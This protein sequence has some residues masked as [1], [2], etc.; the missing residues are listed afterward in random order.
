[1]TSDEARTGRGA[2]PADRRDE[3]GGI[4]SPPSMVERM[5]LVLDA[6][7]D[8]AAR[9]RL[10]EIALRTGLPRSTSHRILDQLVRLGWL[11][12]SSN[13]YALGR[14][15]LRLGG[16]LDDTAEL[17]A[18]AAPVLEKLH[19][20]TGR[21]VC[22]GVLDGANVVFLDRIGGAGA[23]LPSH[24]G[25]RAPA[26]ATALGK[27]MLARLSPEDVDSVFRRGLRPRTHATIT[28]LAV[29]HREL[30]RVRTRH[31]LAFERDEHAVGVSGVAV[32]ISGGER[33]GG[34]CV[35]EPTAG[36]SPER[37][38]PLVRDAATRI[39]RRLAPDHAVAEPVPAPG[40]GIMKRFLEVLDEDA[41]V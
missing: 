15:S 30:Q 8:R 17:R 3:R 11:T 2:A 39:A 31:G 7:G 40:T 16:R 27:A 33:I 19:G 10:D 6:F 37:L 20:G 4:S 35:Y 14:R 21:V 23:A 34:I 41:I 38:A 29:L 12:H 1:M 5:T 26:H 9:L 25:G 28:D 13:G 32:A 24:V 36:G 18:A 22:L